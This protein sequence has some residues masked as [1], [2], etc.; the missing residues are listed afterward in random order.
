MRNNRRRRV[1]RG[2]IRRAAMMYVAVL[3][4]VSALGVAG[5]GAL[6]ENRHSAPS[7]DV[8]TIPLALPE[9]N[10]TQA[11]APASVETLAA[12]A[13]AAE[14]DVEYLPV[15]RRADIDQKRVAITVDD[16]FQV[17]NLETI[18]G[19]ARSAGGRITIFP[20]G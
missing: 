10:V 6:R 18:I 17:K 16:C 14:A 5:I 19:A 11:E 1:R 7:A 3:A 9:E 8:Y 2:S 20:I 13:S 4:A 15:Y 12:E